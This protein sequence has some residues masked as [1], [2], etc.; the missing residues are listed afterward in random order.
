[1]SELS[2]ASPPVGAMLRMLAQPRKAFSISELAAV[3]PLSRSVLYRAIREG[4]LIARKLGDR[5]IVLAADWDA[6]LQSLPRVGVEVAAAPE[7]VGP[8]EARAKK[9]ITA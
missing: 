8:R 5:T 2:E 7:P 3:G 6:F 4:A 1:M 9:A